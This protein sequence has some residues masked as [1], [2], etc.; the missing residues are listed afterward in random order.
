MNLPPG[1]Y[2]AEGPAGWAFARPAAQAWVSEALA[3]GLMLRQHA[4]GQPQVRAL[5]GRGPVYVVRG[6]GAEWVVRPYRRGGAVAGPLLGDR[7]LRLGPPRPL[8]EAQASQEARRRAIPTPAVVAGAVYPAGPF[9]RADLVTEYI[10]DSRDLAALLFQRPPADPH[11]R[12]RGLREA[13]HLIGRMAKAGVEHPDL[14]A[15]NILL[16]GEKWAFT[17]VLLDLDRC[18]VDQQLDPLSPLPML[19]RLERSLGNL[20]ARA[21]EPLSERDR[22]VLRQ[23]VETAP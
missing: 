7:Y 4:A 17:A 15:K 12:A 9:Y 1:F 21:G 2:E 22:E 8:A 16:V 18:R 14:N 19:R 11:E 3:Q 13:G 5:E 20:A 10:P 6:G 23:G